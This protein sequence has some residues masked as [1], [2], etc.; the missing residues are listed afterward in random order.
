MRNNK[1]FGPIMDAHLPPP[2]PS[3]PQ[4]YV[5]ELRWRF[6]KFS[7]V[8][9][10]DKN[11]FNIQ[12]SLPLNVFC[13]KII[14]LLQKS[15][16]ICPKYM[17]IF[18]DFGYLYH[19]TTETCWFFSLSFFYQGKFVGFCQLKWPPINS[20]FHKKLIQIVFKAQTSIGNQFY[21]KKIVILTDCI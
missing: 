16:Q 7:N 20:K 5:L 10:I 13:P 1:Q 17:T 3:P 8:S 21:F 19:F 12:F 18:L 6:C 11:G 15:L 14:S 4:C 9:K 2:T